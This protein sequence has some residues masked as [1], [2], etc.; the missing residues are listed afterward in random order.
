MTKVLFDK[1]LAAITAASAAIGGKDR[2]SCSSQIIYFFV[3]LV[4]SSVQ[5]IAIL[6]RENASLSP[7]ATSLFMWFLLIGGA[8]GG[9]MLRR[10]LP[11][12]YL[13]THAK[14]IVRLGCALIAT[15]A[16]LVLGLLINSA[17]T[18]FNA[19][20]DEI[21][22]LTANIILIDHMLLQ[23]GPDAREAR[24]LLR[25]ALPVMADRLWS[26]GSARAN[27]AFSTS[28]PGEAAYRAVRMLRPA[29][30]E[31]R[32]YRAQALQ[33]LTQIAQTRFILFEQA[34][35]SIPRPF[36]VVLAFW[37]VLLFSSF[38]LFSPM[39]PAAFAALVLIGL[40]ASGAVFLILEMYSPFSGIMQLDSEPLRKALPP[41][42]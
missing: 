6:P 32:F 27:V 13:D 42:S 18:T 34:S 25:Q 21:R 4:C 16:G 28:G 40:S 23:Y 19:Q 10:R 3:A 29:D 30:D 26:D 2:R 5:T 12:H 1:S 22:Q 7:L 11:E 9:A 37:L 33:V 24:E 17:N 8:L 15:I 31:Q 38:S 41:L 14:D 35:G 20:R 39:S 36:L